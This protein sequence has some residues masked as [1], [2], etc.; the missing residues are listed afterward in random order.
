MHVIIRSMKILNK[1]RG[2][3]STVLG[4][5]DIHI[6]KKLPLYCITKSHPK[7]KQVMNIITP[8]FSTYTKVAIFHL[9]GTYYYVQDVMLENSTLVATFIFNSLTHFFFFI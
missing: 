5:E 3:F 4:K 7:L 8:F 1:E 2:L 9:L 6:F